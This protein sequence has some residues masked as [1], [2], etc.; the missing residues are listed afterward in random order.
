MI[1]VTPDGRMLAFIAPRPQH[2]RM[3][4]LTRRF[5]MVLL[6]VAAALAAAGFAETNGRATS[7]DGLKYQFFSKPK[8]HREGSYGNWFPS[9]SLKYKLSANFD[10]QLGFSSTIRRPTFRDV[11][12]VWVINDD[13]LT[14]SAPNT[15]LKPETS[16]NLAARLAYYF[17]PVGLVEVSAFLKQITN[18]TRSIDGIVATGEDNGFEGQFAG[19]TLRQTRNVGSARIRGV[20]QVTVT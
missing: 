4:T 10:A 11:A 20:G 5:G 7:I 6:I 8:I 13:N 2:M 1:L 9:A 3:K 19:Y 14:V 12:G 16:R 17:E 15:S 18:Y